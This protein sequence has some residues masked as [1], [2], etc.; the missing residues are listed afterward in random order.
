[1]RPTSGPW[2]RAGGVRYRNQTGRNDFV[3]LKAAYDRK[4]LYFYAQ[5]VLRI[6]PA[7]DPHW[8]LLFIDTDQ[9]AD[10][11]WLGYDYVV[12]LQVR[13]ERETTMKAWR[14]GAW[15]PAGKAEYRVNGNG[16]E[17]KLARKLVSQS[18]GPAFDFHWADNIQSFE[19]VSELGVNGDSAPNRRWNYRFSVAR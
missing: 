3:M 16:M 9:R 13:S 2:T 4:S 12:N 15:Q 10:T 18:K 6:T 19:G 11:G 1:M 7:T 14:N 17:L 8:M 5:T